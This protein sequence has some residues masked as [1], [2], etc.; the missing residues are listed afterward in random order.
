MSLFS[1]RTNATEGFEIASKE[2]AEDDRLEQIRRGQKS[3]Q[4]DVHPATNQ[5]DLEK[6]PQ[7]TE[8]GKSLPS[9]NRSGAEPPVPG[10][11]LAQRPAN[12]QPKDGKLT[13]G[14]GEAMFG[15]RRFMQ[16]SGM[17]ERTDEDLY[18]EAEGL[19]KSYRSEWNLS[20][21]VKM[22]KGE[23]ERLAQKA[24]V[25]HQ[26]LEEE[27]SD[28]G[29]LMAKRNALMK[30]IMTNPET[31]YSIAVH[32][33]LGADLHEKARECINRAYSCQPNSFL[34]EK[35]CD[36]GVELW[37]EKNPVEPIVAKEPEEVR[38]KR[39][40]KDWSERRG[41]SLDIA[42]RL[43]D[44]PSRDAFLKKEDQQFVKKHNITRE[45]LDNIKAYVID[46][47]WK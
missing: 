31:L 27:M 35:L 14:P 3:D 23:Q 24:S 30:T 43:K 32:C 8:G 15:Q 40:F 34:R 12:D 4:Q 11:G 45:E 19:L 41:R 17:K 1:I 47:N 21:F 20:T 28:G 36:L 7:K 22:S 16:G 39:I 9:V 2:K 25:A 46:H 33:S 18:K 37:S 44:Q 13:S 10:E 29:P 5:S 42:R 38:K 26:I 6:I